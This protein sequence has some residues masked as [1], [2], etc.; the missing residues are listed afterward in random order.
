MTAYRI[1]FRSD[2]RDGAEVLRVTGPWATKEPL[3]RLRDDCIYL[4]RFRTLEKARF[5][6]GRFVQQYNSGRLL[7][8]DGYATPAAVRCELA[9]VA[10][11]S[12]SALVRNTGGC[13][14][15]T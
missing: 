9:R 6:V 2:F 8:R 5:V 3:H 1:Q 14:R 4:H 11:W 12:R 7:Q 10:D 13:T 15:A